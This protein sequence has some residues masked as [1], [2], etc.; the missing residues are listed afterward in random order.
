[1]IDSFHLSQNY[2]LLLD[3]SYQG[4]EWSE[5]GSHPERRISSCT[6]SSL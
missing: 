2:F 4:L 1:M 6:L 5:S 3:N